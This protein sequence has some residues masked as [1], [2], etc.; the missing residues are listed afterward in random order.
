MSFLLDT[1]ICSAHIKGNRQV[2]GYFLQHAG[3]LSISAMTVAELTTWS[4]RASL[5][6]DTRQALTAFLRD[7]PCLPFDFDVAVKYGEVY[8]QLLAS[9]KPAP[10]ADLQI[11]VTALAHDL[12]LVTHN[13][14]DF[15]YVPHLRIVNWLA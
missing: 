9:G 8:A 15:A 13:T 11:A 2:F 1:N 6:N 10:L 3:Q 4:H 5:S 12:T 7:I 14:A